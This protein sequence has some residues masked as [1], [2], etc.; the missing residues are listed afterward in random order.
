[1]SEIE[2]LIKDFLEIK[3]LIGCP[4]FEL[5]QWPDS[6]PT[7]GDQCGKPDNN[8]TRCTEFGILCE[9]ILISQLLYKISGGCHNCRRIEFKGEWIFLKELPIPDD[10][11]LIPSNIQGTIWERVGKVPFCPE[12]QPEK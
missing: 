1:M 5:E 11:I 4:F 10:E 3:D 12:C 8:F 7:G 9:D 2:G 6:C